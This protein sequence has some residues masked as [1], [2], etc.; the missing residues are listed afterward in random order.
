[1]RSF[2]GHYVPLVLFTLSAGSE[3]NKDD[4]SFSRC[5]SKFIVDALLLIWENQ[6]LITNIVKLTNA[7]H[8]SKLS[9]IKLATNTHQAYIVRQRQ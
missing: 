8:N 9:H 1:M 7:G 4:Q 2:G 5:E 3:V 6:L